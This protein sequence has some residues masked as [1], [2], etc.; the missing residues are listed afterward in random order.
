MNTWCQRP[1]LEVTEEITQSQGGLLNDIDRLKEHH[2]ISDPGGEVA[3]C[4][5]ASLSFMDFETGMVRTSYSYP[6]LLLHGSSS[7]SN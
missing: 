3:S 7:D 1:A 6:R 4:G 2:H 5:D